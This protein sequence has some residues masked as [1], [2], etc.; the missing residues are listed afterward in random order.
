MDVEMRLAGVSSVA[1][2]TDHLPGGDNVA[3]LHLYCTGPHMGIEHE[4]A[5]AYI[6]NGM[7]ACGII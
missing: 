5:L 7:I 2:V 6:D 4:V 1:N 3:G